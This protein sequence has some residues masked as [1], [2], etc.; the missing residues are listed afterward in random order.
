M[1][2][3]RLGVVESHFAEL[4]WQNEPLSSKELVALCERELHW[5]KSTTY[6][7]LK[8]LCEKGL[9]RNEQS[10]ITSRISRDEFDAIQSE[11]FVEETFDGSLPAFIAAFTK[12]K[13]LSAD[14]IAQIRQMIDSCGEE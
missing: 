14:E 5:K 2:D 1:E 8:K 13:E 11:Q 3:I 7:V 9:F 12:R 4:I 10:V 6:T